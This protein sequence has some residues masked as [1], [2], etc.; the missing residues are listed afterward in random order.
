ML[1]LEFSLRLRDPPAFTT[2]N[3]LLNDSSQRSPRHCRPEGAPHSSELTG[4]LGM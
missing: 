1:R 4:S 2:L 3:V